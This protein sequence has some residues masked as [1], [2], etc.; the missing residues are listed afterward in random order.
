[1]KEFYKITIDGKEYDVLLESKSAKE[2]DY[3]SYEKTLENILEQAQK[4]FWSICIDFNRHQI[5]VCRNILWVAAALLA[6][7][8]ALFN[9]FSAFV[10]PTSWLGILFFISSILS[11]IS[12]GLCLYGM[13]S[14][15]G[16][17][18]PYKNSWGTL[19]YEAYKK[20]EE[21]TKDLHI[22][23]LT[24]SIKHID[25]SNKANQSTNTRRAKIFRVT[26]WLLISSFVLNLLAGLLFLFSTSSVHTCNNFS[27]TAENYVR[28]IMNNENSNSTNSEKSDVPVPEKPDVPVPEKPDTTGSSQFYLD[29]LDPVIPDSAQVLNEK[30]DND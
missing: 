18:M 17:T 20:L 25:E 7:Y 13:P 10:D 14:R 28:C 26:S 12:F 8:A 1:M 15:N 6:A 22:S 21:K 5:I 27:Q 4:E 19:S 9:K 11:V 2:F 23:Y 24:N 29:S 3:K 30:K 16:Y